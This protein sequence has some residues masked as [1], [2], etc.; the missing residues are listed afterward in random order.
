MIDKENAVWKTFVEFQTLI[1][2]EGKSIG[3]D[4][5]GTE[6]STSMALSLAQ[7]HYINELRKEIQSL[8]TNDELKRSC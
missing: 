2:T 1:G 8:F 6:Q 7:T 5:F 4:L 3:L